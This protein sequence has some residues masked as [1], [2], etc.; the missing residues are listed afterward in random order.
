M[1]H[2][3]TLSWQHATYLYNCILIYQYLETLLNKNFHASFKAY[4]CMCIQVQDMTL[5]VLCVNSPVKHF[6]YVLKKPLLF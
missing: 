3:N 6:W 5:Y 4:V 1:S 2:K